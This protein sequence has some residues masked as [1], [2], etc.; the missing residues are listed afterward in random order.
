[1]IT[2]HAL[3]RRTDRRTNIMA[4]TGRFVL[5][6]ASRANTND[7][8]NHHV[9]HK[10]WQKRWIATKEASRTGWKLSSRSVDRSHCSHSQQQQQDHQRRNFGLIIN[11]VKHWV[12]V[13]GR[14]QNRV[15][16]VHFL[17]P[18][19]FSGKD[20]GLVKYRVEFIKFSFAPNI[21]CNLAGQ[22]GSLLSTRKTSSSA[23]AERPR[24]LDQRFQMG[25]QFEAIIDWG[26]IFR[27]IATRR[28]L[29]LW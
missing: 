3:L 4:T 17:T 15:K 24:E 13:I 19:I 10:N 5:T 25:G 28:N 2:M 23:M 12:V 16:S 1:M 8:N 6:K 26:V 7:N 27:A 11:Y 21:W 22:L 20:Y 18:V 9:W 29:R 14:V